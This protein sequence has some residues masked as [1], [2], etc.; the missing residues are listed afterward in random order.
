MK[1]TAGLTLVMATVLAPGAVHGLGLR[2]PDQDPKAMA[3]GNAFTATADDPSAVYYNPAGIT[4]ST[5]H[6]A[7]AGVNIVTLGSEREANG[8]SI[9]TKDSVHVLPQVYYTYGF[10]NVPIALGLGFYAPYGLGMEWPNN[11][12]FRQTSIEGSM[13][14]LTLNP[15]VAWKPLST[16]SIAAGPTLNYGDTELRSGLYPFSKFNGTDMTRFRGDDTAAGFNAGVL[17]QPLE[18]H[19][20]GLTYRSA[21]SMNFSGDVSTSIPAI[22]YSTR[23]D[24]SAKIDFPQ[25][26]VLGYSFRPTPKWNLEFDV[27]WTDWDS[28]NTVDLKSATGATLKELPF[29]YQSSFMYEWGVTRYFEN[30]YSLSGGYMFSENSVPDQ[31]F[32]PGIPDSDR[33]I[34]SIGVGKQYKRIR[35]DAAYQ[36]AYG[37]SRDVSSTTPGVSGSYTFLSNALALSVGINF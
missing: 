23:T 20:F 26:V 22:G 5:G 36:F 12:P 25:Q 9:D 24:A 8:Q 17:W 2:I 21:T 19:S 34:F 1:H 15:V 7:S 3:R 35:W 32:S 4:Q 27:D 6:N 14:Y 13:T 29:N 18:Q 33:H 10:T 31:W 28:L 16:L 30:G 11:T 37:P